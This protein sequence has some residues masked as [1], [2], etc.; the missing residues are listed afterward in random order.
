MVPDG[1]LEITKVSGLTAALAGKA[2]QDTL[3]YERDI[4]IAIQGQIAGTA[5]ALGYTQQDLVDLIGV[6]A[7]KASGEELTNGLLTRATVS[8]LVAGLATKRDKIDSFSNLNVNA[9][10]TINAD[11]TGT[12]NA[13]LTK[14]VVPGTISDSPTS[15]EIGSTVSLARFTHGHHIDSFTRADGVGRVLYLNY[16]I[17]PL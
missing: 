15:A 16:H 13:N 2:S 3:D 5:A 1:A 8:S 12:L 11:V 7:S 4:R 9:I 10:S 6:V 17:K 14:V